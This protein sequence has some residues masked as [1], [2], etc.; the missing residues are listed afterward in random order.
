M[1]I[2]LVLGSKPAGID[3]AALVGASQM[4]VLV[5]FHDC[6]RAF[7]SL[8]DVSR[9]LVLKHESMESMPRQRTE[10][11]GEFKWAKRPR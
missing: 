10:N 8:S 4:D 7:T 6:P 9:S 3:R 1:R 5:S 2:F 11:V